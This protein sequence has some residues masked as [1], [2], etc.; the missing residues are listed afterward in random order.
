MRQQN[1]VLNSKK[2]IVTL[3]T[4]KKIYRDL[5]EGKT[6]SYKCHCASCLYHFIKGK[7]KK[8]R[9]DKD[10]FFLSW[11]A[12]HNSNIKK[13]SNYRLF[14]LNKHLN[15][16]WKETLKS[17]Y[18]I[19]GQKGRRIYFERNH[20]NR[21]EQYQIVSRYDK[22]FNIPK[23]SHSKEGDIYF[24]PMKISGF[25]LEAERVLESVKKYAE[26]IYVPPANFLPAKDLVELSGIFK[27]SIRIVKFLVDSGKDKK[28][29]YSVISRHFHLD[30]EDLLILFDYLKRKNLIIWNKENKEISLHPDWEN[31]M[32]IY[33]YWLDNIHEEIRDLSP[34]SIKDAQKA[35]I[36]SASSVIRNSILTK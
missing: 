31:S 35:F 6:H 10:N 3:E 16:N 7:D 28:I 21:P 12:F 36:E 25:L 29:K 13:N 20:P 33:L 18:E 24:L 11:L 17:Y 30:Q 22:K 32:E 1:I 19:T 26:D 34:F 2:K 14:P 15:R 8:A 9:I 5:K 27:I 4:L 23:T